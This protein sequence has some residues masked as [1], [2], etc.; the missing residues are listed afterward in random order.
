MPVLSQKLIFTLVPKRAPFFLRP[1]V[2]MI[3][4][5]LLNTLVEPR[6]KLHH[7]FVRTNFPDD[8]VA[9]G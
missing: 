1:M 7:D 4:G 9:S 3:F 6:L 5:M 2:K 8:L